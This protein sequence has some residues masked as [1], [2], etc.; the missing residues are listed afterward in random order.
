[1]LERYRL[2]EL[3]SEEK[4][5][6]RDALAA[7]SGL[8]SRLEKLDESDR[9]LRLLYPFDSLGLAAGPDR[10]FS[11]ARFFEPKFFEPQVKRMR[12]SFLASIAAVI[13]LC[14]LFPA[15]HFM[16]NEGGTTAGTTDRVK[17]SVQAG[18]ELSVFLKGDREIPLMD[19]SVLREGHTVQLAY[20]AP[21][22]ID[23]YGVIF[24]IDGRFEVTMHYPYREGQSSLLVSGK[25]TYL[26]EA[27]T[28]D[29][30]PGYEIFVM[31]VS[32]APLDSHTVLREVRN[33]AKKQDQS[34]LNLWS[35]TD[36]SKSIFRD[37][38]VE[39]VT[40]LKE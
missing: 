21:A 35:I 40:V 39:T 10:R 4:Q 13:A 28:L 7:E 27:Y 30:A 16:R 14:I 11:K 8:R 17:G 18:P 31:V 6:V 36:E 2:G 20:T 12:P 34:S 15:L 1:M 19:K 22:G 9:E 23:R 3:L 33:M 25:Q 26:N 5:A 37:C 38:E 29:D 32:E 24:S